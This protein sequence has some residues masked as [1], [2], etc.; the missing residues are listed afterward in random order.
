MHVSFIRNPHYI[1]LQIPVTATDV[2]LLIK[3]PGLRELPDLSSNAKL[4]ILDVE[5]F[6]WM[7]YALLYP[8]YLTYFRASAKK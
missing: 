7:F 3:S 2:K 5:H 6:G 4:T 8:Q 1:L